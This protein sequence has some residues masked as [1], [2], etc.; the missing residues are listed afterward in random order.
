MKLAAIAAC[1]CLMLGAMSSYAQDRSTED[2]QG[3]NAAP[4]PGTAT[5]PPAGNTTQ[6]SSALQSG[7]AG[8]TG[9]QVTMKQCK[10]L[11]ALESKSPKLERDPVKDNACAQLLGKPMPDVNGIA[12]S[13]NKD[14]AMSGHQGADGTLLTKKEC[15][16]LVAAEA[17]NPNLQR[18][19]AKDRR[20]ARLLGTTPAQ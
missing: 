2:T 18:D 8:D 10:D 19:P 7:H 12:V 11:F 15:T 9:A 17:K 13:Q 16:D 5:N 6:N 3:K 20:C 1:T 4:A 14:A